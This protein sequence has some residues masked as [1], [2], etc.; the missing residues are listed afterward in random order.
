[1]NLNSRL[2]R[3]NQFGGLNECISIHM[4]NSSGNTGQ[5]KRFYFSLGILGKLYTLTARTILMSQSVT[6]M[7][8]LKKREHTELYCKK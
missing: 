2:T 8:P 7:H 3:H 4:G 1:M 5:G 6:C